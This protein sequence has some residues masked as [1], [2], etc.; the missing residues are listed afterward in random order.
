MLEEEESREPDFPPKAA[1]F[2][3][4]PTISTD[5][6]AAGGTCTGMSYQYE[7]SNQWMEGI[8]RSTRRNGHAIKN[9]GSVI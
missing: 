3:P 4:S 7:G 9:G 1:E 5:T 6:E 2:L 8:E